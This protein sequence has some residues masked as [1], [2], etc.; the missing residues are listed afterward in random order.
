[1][2]GSGEGG[3]AQPEPEHAAPQQA[4]APMQAT[5]SNQY[6]SA[7][8]TT[9]AC[10]VLMNAQGVPQPG[11][12]FEVPSGAVVEIEPLGS[13]ASDNCFVS[14]AG[15]DSA[16]TGPRI[17]IKK[18]SVVPRQVRVRNLSDITVYS[19]TANDGVMLTVQVDSR[20]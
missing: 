11:P 6:S 2:A 16:K 10:P 14:T 3:K 13:N 7:R 12:G 20:S 9:F 5:Q 17:Q 4:A 1:M 8:T 19:D 18:N 15:G